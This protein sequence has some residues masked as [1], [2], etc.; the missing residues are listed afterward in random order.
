MDLLGAM[1]CTVD[2]QGRLQVLDLYSS[3]YY[4]FWTCLDPASG[5]VTAAGEQVFTASLG[6]GRLYARRGGRLVSY[7]LRDAAALQAW[8]ENLLNARTGGK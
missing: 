6:D 8:A 3:Y 4:G 2:G 7:P 1:S 5:A